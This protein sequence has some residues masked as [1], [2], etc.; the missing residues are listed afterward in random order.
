[1][2]NT[3]KTQRRT[4]KQTFTLQSYAPCLQYRTE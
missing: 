4:V 3:L 1:M 2:T